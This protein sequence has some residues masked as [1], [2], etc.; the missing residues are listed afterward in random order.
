MMSTAFLAALAVIQPA[1]APAIPALGSLAFRQQ[2]YS[3]LDH[4]AAG[5]FAAAAAAAASLPGPEIKVEIRDAELNEQARGIFRAAIQKGIGIWEASGLKGARPAFVDSGGD[6]IFSYMPE[7]VPGPD[8]KPRAL[9]ILEGY[10]AGEP[11][12]EA[13]I[14][15]R[16]AG[17]GQTTEPGDVSADAAFAFGRAMGLDELP[18][19]ASIMARSEGGQF[20]APRAS[21]FDLGFAEAALKASEE[22]RRLAREKL[23]VAAGR[24]RIHIVD[25]AL[26]FGLAVQ[27]AP[28]S[29]TLQ[30]ASLGEAPLDVVILP[31][32]GCFVAPPIGELAPGEVRNAEILVRTLEF[33][34]PVEHALYVYS[35]DPEA[36][37]RRVP[38]QGLVQPLY[39]FIDPQGSETAY[40]GS[41]PVER[42]IILALSDPERLDILEVDADGA[43]SSVQA[44]PWTGDL[45]DPFAPG[46]VRW[47]KGYRLRLTLSGAQVFGRF[48]ISISARTTDERLPV[49]RFSIFAQRGIVVRPSTLYLGEQSGGPFK[50]WALAS[51]PGRPF[52]VAGIESNSPHLTAAWEPFG[53]GEVKIN[54]IYDGKAPAGQFSG[55]VTLLI[56]DPE[57]PRLIVPVS[58]VVK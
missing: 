22:I 7:P 12:I 11:R 41:Q 52:R 45:P 48:P 50:A 38:T 31:D 18:R 47:T 20:T 36:P 2:A 57:Q 51:R 54:V 25:S 23:I 19:S 24:P 40:I 53:K 32:C 15:L 27:G 16:R 44:E 8:G 46:R 55:T 21:G 3:A 28:M 10:A 9:A 43:E 1:K 37:V 35:S 39:R 14:S 30:I 5:D 49:I 4:L 29:R 34:G 56:D 13:V 58:A 26:D 33:P 17:R 42:E 6:L